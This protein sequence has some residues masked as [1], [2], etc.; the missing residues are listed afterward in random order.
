MTKVEGRPTHIQKGLWSS[1]RVV[2]V[3]ISATIIGVLVETG[4]IRVSGFEGLHDLSAEVKIF[5]GLAIFCIFSQLIILNFVRNKI[6]KPFLSHNKHIGV[7]NK[8]IV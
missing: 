1:N 4:I 7:I 3:V 5:V 6:G 8:S 2:F